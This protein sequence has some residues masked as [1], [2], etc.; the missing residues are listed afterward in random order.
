M[1]PFFST[2]TCFPAGEPSENTHTLCARSVG[3]VS[4]D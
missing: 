4:A 3:R 1:M 2:Q